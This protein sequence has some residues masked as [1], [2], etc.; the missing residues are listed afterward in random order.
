[1]RQ[2]PSLERHDTRKLHPSPLLRPADR[3]TDRL[4]LIATDCSGQAAVER[5]K[6]ILVIGTK[7]SDPTMCLRSLC[8]FAPNNSEVRNRPLNTVVGVA[9]RMRADRVHVYFVAPR[10]VYSST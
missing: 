5:P 7:E 10:N 4:H 3:R 6:K 9:T 1:M 2:R 8:E